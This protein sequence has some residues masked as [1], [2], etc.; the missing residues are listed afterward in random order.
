[1]CGILHGAFHQRCATFDTQHPRAA[2]R[3]GQGKVAQPAEKIDD[4]FTRLRVEQMQ[5]AMHHRA[6]HLAIYLG[7]FGRR[8]WHLDAEFRQGVGKR[9]RVQRMEWHD[10]LRPFGLQPELDIVRIGKGA[11]HSLIA[12][13]KRLHD[14][15]HQYVHVFAAGHF[16][17]RQSFADGK[18]FDQLRQQ[19]DQ[20]GNFRWQ[21]FTTRHIRH[22]AVALLVKAHQRLALFQHMAHRQARTLAVAPR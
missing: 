7:E 11:Q 6:I 2:A 20:P 13:G 3:D 21:Y 5:C 18:F 22:V 4:A 15:Q 16:D 19:R 8:E 14:A 17:L 1:M 9:W 12:G 10:G